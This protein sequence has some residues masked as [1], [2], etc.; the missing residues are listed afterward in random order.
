MQPSPVPRDNPNVKRSTPPGAR[1]RI[2]GPVLLKGG[3]ARPE[4]RVLVHGLVY[5]GQAFA[6]LMDGDGWTFRY[7][8]D[9]GLLNLA[10]M[11][12]ELRACD[13]VYQV[14]G[15]VTRGKFL[16]A[17]HLFRKKTI[18]MHWV[19]SDTVDEQNDVAAGNADPW[20]FR[21]VHHWA[22]SDW[23][24]REVNALGLPCDRVPLPSSLVPDRP[25][26]MPEEFRVLVYVPTLTRSSLYGLDSILIA[27]RSLPDVP[28]D[29]VGLRD[30]PIPDAPRNLHV[31]PRI[32]NLAEFYRRAS[33]VWR[34]VR[35]DGLSWMVMESL[36]HGRHVL[37]TYAFPGCIHATNSSEACEQIARLH[38]LH[39]RGALQKNQM[40]ADFIAQG[41]YSPRFLRR[42]IHA[43][44]ERM[45]DSPQ[46][47]GL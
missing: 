12:A 4:R 19:G 29:L 13:I 45:L 47:P 7:F 43:R 24:V 26:P 46:A 14:G 42:E 35:H 30:G 40:G 31:Y 28:F 6:N 5:F 15:R 22:E 27:A 21:S 25:G 33:V 39:Q 37:W 9:R 32:P 17:A 36:G 8:P 41:G 2:S 16:R 20:V 34:P 10:A 3:V 23:M 11:A 38:R 1:S 44:L 18:V